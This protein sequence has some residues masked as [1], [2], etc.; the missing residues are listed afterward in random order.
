[1]FKKIKQK[2]RKLECKECGKKYKGYNGWLGRHIKKTNHRKY[3]YI[4]VKDKN[5]KTNKTL[6]RADE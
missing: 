1:V 2:M 3:K 5:A 6:E 4:E